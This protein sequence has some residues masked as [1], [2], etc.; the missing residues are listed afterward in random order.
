MNTKRTLLTLVAGIMLAANHAQAAWTYSGSTT[1]GTLTSGGGS[2]RITRI[3]AAA[4]QGCGANNLRLPATLTHIG[5]G[6]FRSS[7]YIAYTPKTGLFKGNFKLYYDGLNDKGTLQ[8]KTAPPATP[9]SW[10]PAPPP[11]PASAPA[12]PRS[13]R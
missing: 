2:L 13:T 4:F 9:A 6:A 5:D 12:P 1:S 8:H 7:P 11:S 10:S 3:Y